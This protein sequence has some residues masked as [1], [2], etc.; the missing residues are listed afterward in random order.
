MA[1]IK[2]ITI[3]RINSYLD[4]ANILLLLAPPHSLLS[5]SLGSLPFHHENILQL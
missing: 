3:R 5:S 1:Q 2:K 4:V